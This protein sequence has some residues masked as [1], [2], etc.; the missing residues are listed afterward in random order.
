MMKTLLRGVAQLLFVFAGL[1]FFVGGLAINILT[2]TELMLA[3]VE[4]VGLAVA[5]GALGFLAE[6]V[7]DNL[8]DGNSNGQ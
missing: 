1:S 8:D 6:S 3:E 7:G 4:G 2:K 5:C